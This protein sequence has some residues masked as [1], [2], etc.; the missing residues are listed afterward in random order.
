MDPQQN[1]RIGA[2]QVTYLALTNLLG[3]VMGIIL[4]VVIKPGAH[5]MEKTNNATSEAGLKTTDIFADLI[6]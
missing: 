3:A 5:M 2:L 6:R 1:G 4:A